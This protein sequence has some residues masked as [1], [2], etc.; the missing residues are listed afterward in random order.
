MLDSDLAELYSV[1]TK[2]LNKA[3][4][5]NPRRFPEDFM[6]QLDPGEHERLRFQFGTSK[7]GRGGR[8]SAPYAFTQEGI[9]MLSSILRSHRAIEVNV[10]IMRAFVDLRQVIAEHRD[11]AKKIADHET[12]IIG[13]TTDVQQIFQLILPLLDGPVKKIKRIGFKAERC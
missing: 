7:E 6:F 1:R 2:E 3:V 13:L 10:A 12:K 5:R 11:V 9:A 8:R 4:K